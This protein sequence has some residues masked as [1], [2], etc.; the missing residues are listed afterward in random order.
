MLVYLITLLFLI[1]PFLSKGIGVV[2]DSKL[3]TIWCFIVLFLISGLSYNLGADTRGYT[4]GIGYVEA[5][6]NVHGLFELTQTDFS[7]ETWQPGFVYLL[8]IFRTFTSNYLI[9]QLFHAFLVN[10]IVVFFLKENTH[11]LGICLF[12]YC[13]LYYFDLNFEIQRESYAIVLGLLMYLFLEKHDG[14]LAKLLVILGAVLAFLFI[15]RSAFILMMYPLLKDVRIG[16]KGLLICFVATLFIQLLW[17]KFS[18]LGLLLDAVAGDVYQGYFLK[19]VR[20]ANEGIGPI[21]FLW[22]TLWRVVVP[23]LF[24]Y[25]SYEYK[26]PNYLVF[27]VLCVAFENLKYFSFAFHRMYGYFSPFYW[28]VLTDGVIY[29]GQKIKMMNK[30]L[31][32]VAFITCMM[33]YIIYTY[34]SDYFREDPYPLSDVKYVYNWYFPY[35]SILEPGNSYLK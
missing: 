4:S 18:S 9:Y 5:F 14:I 26:K 11:Y 22:L 24:A 27:F 1:F 10:Y 3:R 2:D 8:S 16:R 30:G 13:M 23:Y 34:H 33:G 7:H 28:L 35:Q 31:V 12:F 20:E 19:D 29:I 17:I 21:Y 6:N 32:R 25:F 15:H